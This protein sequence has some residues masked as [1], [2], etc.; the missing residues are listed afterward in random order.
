MSLGPQHLWGSVLRHL[1]Q[2]PT[3]ELYASVYV[4]F[5]GKETE[6]QKNETTS[7]SQPVAEL[8]SHLGSA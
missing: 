8:E 1:P 5:T 3:G 7:P 2:M 6:A 4:L